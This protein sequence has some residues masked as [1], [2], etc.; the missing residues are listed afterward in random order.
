M[1]TASNA[2]G[3]RRGESNASTVGNTTEMDQDEGDAR[4]YPIKL[5]GRGGFGGRGLGREEAA[6]V[7]ATKPATAIGSVDPMDSLTSSMSSLKFIPHSVRVARGRGR[8]RGA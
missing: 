7:T 8:G 3:R 1:S 5:H 2:T 6:A 4:R